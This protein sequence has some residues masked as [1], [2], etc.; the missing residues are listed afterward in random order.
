M[1]AQRYDELYIQAYLMEL[2]TLL[3]GG[4]YFFDI[5]SM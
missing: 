3:E 1:K 4:G 2:A 5:Q